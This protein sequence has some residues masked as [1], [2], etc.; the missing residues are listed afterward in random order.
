MPLL[1]T[2]FIFP[3][4]E[5]AGFIIVG[6][7]IGVLPTLALIVATAV[8]G[9][10]LLRIQGF[11]VLQRLN[12]D[13]RAD[14]D[15]GRD[16]IHGVMIVLAGILLLIPGFVTDIIGFLMF[17]PPI[18]DLVWKYFRKDISVFSQRS[19]S[20]RSGGASARKPESPVV[21]LDSSDFS[22]DAKADPN[23]PWIDDKTDKPKD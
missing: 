23:S 22:S 13:M 16:M 5:I 9:A 15:P 18:R 3:F 12:D 8:I 4:V 2:L 19:F 21:D 7:A 14:A 20:Y 6:R 17:V 11:S 1:I 10:A